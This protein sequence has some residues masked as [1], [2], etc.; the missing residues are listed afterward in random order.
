MD[1]NFSRNNQPKIT[2]FLM[3]I[4]TKKKVCFMLAPYLLSM[5]YF[6]HQH[7]ID[8]VCHCICKGA[9]FVR[10]L[11]LNVVY[12]LLRDEEF[13]KVK[14]HFLQPMISLYNNSPSSKVKQLVRLTQIEEN[15]VLLISMSHFYES[16]FDMIIR[17]QEDWNHISKPILYEFLSK[18]STALKLYNLSRPNSRNHEQNVRI[19]QSGVRK[20]SARCRLRRP[21]KAIRDRGRRAGQRLLFLPPLEDEQ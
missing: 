14:E 9:K 10:E 6:Q 21:Q 1:L 19:R 11:A 3:K 12:F 16:I 15:L 20:L 18:P 13:A 7:Q 2:D 4:A 5:N 8:F 17:R